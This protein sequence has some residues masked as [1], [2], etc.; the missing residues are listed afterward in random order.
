MQQLCGSGTQTSYAGCVC[1]VGRGPVGCEGRAEAGGKRNTGPW[2]LSHL[3]QIRSQHLPTCLQLGSHM[4]ELVR[5]RSAQHPYPA[6]FPEQSLSLPGVAGLHVMPL[7]KSARQLTLE[8]LADGTLPSTDVP[9]PPA[10]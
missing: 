5:H 4:S 2:R 8:F 7:T 6:P 9:A 1:V 10:S 3:Q